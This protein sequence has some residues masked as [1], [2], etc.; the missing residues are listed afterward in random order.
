PFTYRDY[1]RL[2]DDRRFEVIGGKLFLTPAPRTWHQRLCGELFAALRE[3]VRGQNLGEVLIAPCDVVLSETNVVQ[4][5]LLFV[6]KDRLSIIGEK[7]VSAAPDLLVEV[8]SPGTKMRDRKLKFR[9]Y[10]R[11]G[12]A[13]LWIVDGEARFVEVFRNAGGRFELEKRYSSSHTLHSKILPKL[14][15]ALDSIF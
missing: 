5:D 13:E 10:A 9:L 12:V 2:P 7:Y 8:L 3:H 4:P 6:R 11:F 1:A 14:R 15:L